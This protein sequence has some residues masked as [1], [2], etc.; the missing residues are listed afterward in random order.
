MMFLA[1]GECGNTLAPGTDPAP[2]GWWL[3]GGSPVVLKPVAGT[4][5]LKS[6]RCDVWI[7]GEHGERKTKAAE[8]TDCFRFDTGRDR[9]VWYEL[10]R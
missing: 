3:K 4:L 2:N 9:T 1:A 5:R 8:K 10:A 6:G 7:L